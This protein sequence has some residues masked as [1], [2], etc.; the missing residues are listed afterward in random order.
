VT[1]TSVVETGATRS[2]D[3]RIARF[4]SDLVAYGLVS[5]VALACDYGLLLG[6]VACKVNYLLASLTSFSIGMGVAYA[7]SIRFVFSDR[8]AVS[9]EAEA[10]GF[11]AVGLVGL[12]LTQGLLYL[13]VSHVGLSV[14]LAK[15]PTT[16]IVFVF[17]FLCRRGLVFRGT[18]RARTLPSP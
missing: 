9:R 11:F 15:I 8:R 17:N 14:A 13:F 4:L 12:A 3:G 18:R 5:V 16:G 7:L 1:F 2:S 6:L 10:G